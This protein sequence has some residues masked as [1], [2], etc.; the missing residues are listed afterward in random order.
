MKFQI[1]TWK[2]FRHSLHSLTSSVIF[3][4]FQFSFLM[5]SPLKHLLLSFSLFLIWCLCLLTATKENRMETFFVVTRSSWVPLYDSWFEFVLVCTFHYGVEE[6][7]HTLI[8]KTKRIRVVFV[9]FSQHGK[10]IDNRKKRWNANFSWRDMPTVVGITNVLCR[11]PGFSVAFA[12]YVKWNVFS[13][14][15]IVTEPVYFF[16]I[17]FVLYRQL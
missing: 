6:N 8:T 2:T 10:L 14:W 16:R 7:T 17:Y 9:D 5:S 13:H 15:H 11:Y 1:K 12:W 4:L 3:C